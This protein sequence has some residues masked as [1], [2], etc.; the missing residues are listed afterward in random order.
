[1]T[2]IEFYIDLLT[3]LGLVEE[4]GYI[5]G[6]LS[7][8]KTL[9]LAEDKKQFVL[10]TKEQLANLMEEDE[11]GNPVLKRIPYN[12]L[13]EDVIKG[14][15]M[16][17]KK[18]KYIIER[19]LGH[20]IAYAG[21]LLLKLASNGKL[22]T[23]TKMFINNFLVELNKAK[24][25]NIKSV[26]DDKSLELWA[27]IYKE[28]LSIAKGMTF[29]YL[30]KAGTDVEGNK[31]NR[32]AVLS[33]PVYDEILRTEK[34]PNILGV[35][36]RNKD[37][38]VFEEVLRFIFEDMNTNHTLE[39]GSNDKDCPGF[40]ALYRLYLQV[41]KRI[42][43][44][45]ES[46]KHVDAAAADNIIKLPITEEDLTG[47][48]VYK[49]ELVLIPNENELTRN[50]QTPSRISSDDNA[51]YNRTVGT[52]SPSTQAPAPQPYPNK[53]VDYNHNNDDAAASILSVSRS[54]RAPAP[55]MYQQQPVMV[56]QPMAPM[57]Q[58]PVYNPTPYPE[59]QPPFSG[60]Q[61]PQPVYQPRQVYG[62][63]QQQPPFNPPYSN[64][65]MGYNNTGNVGTVFQYR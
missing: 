42:N 15:S 47:L 8:G 46:L 39:V 52:S 7:N 6:K 35:K 38:V 60:Y 14:D 48:S 45:I 5:F 57:Y 21:E 18:T 64:T 36:L 11:N 9:P 63:Y 49:N 23:K 3:S 51:L 34:E 43:K 29:I 50:I 1:M 22:Q 26:V 4:D 2:L 30:K 58:Q 12:P 27:N 56:Q 55:N 61:Q 62:G 19:K 40:I 13:N 54:M 33:S 41:A 37:K 53:A 28:S 24:G 17:L 44:I 32:L 16:S 20:S 65:N 25:Q 10:P 31:Y 59:Y